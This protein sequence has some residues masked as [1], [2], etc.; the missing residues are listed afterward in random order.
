MNPST[1]FVTYNPRNDFEQTLAVRLQTLGAVHGFDMLLPDRFGGKTLVTKETEFRIKS[2]DYFVLFS[3]SP[4]T[5]T[6]QEEI[7]VAYQ[8][9]K[10]KSRIIIVYDRVKNLR[11][12][13]NCTEVY[14]DSSKSTAQEILQ[15]TLDSIQQN[16]ARKTK[17][18]AQNALGAFLLIGLGLLALNS[19]TSK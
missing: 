11:H 9:L 7:K 1:I 4:L 10:D 15:Q 3:T 12:D 14:I 13:S 17:K 19:A 5:P 16:Q 8:H 18:D 6:V 2:A